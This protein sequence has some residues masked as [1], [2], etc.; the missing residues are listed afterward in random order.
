VKNASSSKAQKTSPQ[1]TPSEKAPSPTTTSKSST[2][3]PAA[4]DQPSE[5]KR[6]VSTAS[7][8]TKEAASTGQSWAWQPMADV[9]KKPQPV[10]P[11]SVPPVR[12][13]IAPPRSSLGSGP[14]VMW[15][16]IA[17]GAAAGVVAGYLLVF[18]I[19]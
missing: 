7:K 18:L 19:R 8:G 12:Q 2:T 9:A 10:A 11:R 17:G 1:K 13:P 14:Q 16:L 6:S 3:A 4:G 5:G 15:P